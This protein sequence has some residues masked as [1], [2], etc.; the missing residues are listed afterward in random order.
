[1]GRASYDGQSR[2]QLIFGDVLFGLSE[3][4][5][6]RLPLA[7]LARY[8]VLLLAYGH[9]DFAHALFR[10]APAL[11][12]AFPQ[13]ADMFALYRA[14]VAKPW[15]FL[16]MQYDKLL[17]LALHLRRTNHMRNDSDRSWPVR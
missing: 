8:V 6:R 16:V 14:P 3:A 10:G 9:M 13:F 12:Q 1:S 15:R 2:G 7:K 4:R 5:A 11:Q 17:A